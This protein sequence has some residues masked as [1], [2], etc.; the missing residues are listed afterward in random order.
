M[1]E[2]EEIYKVMGLDDQKTIALY[3]SVKFAVFSK[4][5]ELLGIYAQY[6]N[7]KQK[8]LEDELITGIK[9]LLFLMLSAYYSK[10]GLF[11]AKGVDLI[12]AK[13]NMIVNEKKI[14]VSV[15]EIE[16]IM[17]EIPVAL[18]LMGITDILPPSKSKLD[19]YAG[20]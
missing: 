7:K 6:C 13:M 10:Y 19:N 15:N 4:Y 12:Y 9:N 16:P 14:E 1:A 3:V 5:S 20:F 11:K 8:Y 2:I 18:N 17:C